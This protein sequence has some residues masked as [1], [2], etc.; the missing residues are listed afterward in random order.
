MSIGMI[1]AFSPLIF[2]IWFAF[3]PESVPGFVLLVPM[4]FFDVI[5]RLIV[6]ANSNPQD[7]DN[8]NRAP[9]IDPNMNTNPEREPG[10]VRIVG[11]VLIFLWFFLAVIFRGSFH[12]ASVTR[13][14]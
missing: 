5:A 8:G 2:G 9:M 10:T 1:I 13:P 12:H 3:L 14:G 7:Y 11:I 4:V 6:A